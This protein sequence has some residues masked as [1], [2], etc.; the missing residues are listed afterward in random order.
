[1][2]NGYSCNHVMLMANISMN[3]QELLHAVLMYIK[4]VDDAE[5][6]Q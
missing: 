6:L 4:S 2:A 1:M 5:S 3:K